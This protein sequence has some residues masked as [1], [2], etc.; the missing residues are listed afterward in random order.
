MSYPLVAYDPYT[1]QTSVPTDVKVGGLYRGLDTLGNDAIFRFVQHVNA[2]A[3]VAGHCAILAAAPTASV[4]KVTNDVSGGATTP[5][6]GPIGAGVYL[7]AVTEN[8]Y[9]F[10]LVKGYH[11]TALGDGSVAAGEMVTAKATD[12]TF[13]TATSTIPV[14]GACLVDDTGSPTT[15]PGLFN[16]L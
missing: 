16:F 13:D 1:Y 8:Y 3:V 4:W 15:F 14:V 2:V 7:F 9:C 5:L 12:G 6:A 10:I 11:A